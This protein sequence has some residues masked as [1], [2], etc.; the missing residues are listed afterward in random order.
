MW[1]RFGPIGLRLQHDKRFMDN[2]KSVLTTSSEADFTLMFVLCWGMWYR[3]NK[4]KME[5]ENITPYASTNMA[6]SLYK[7]FSILK[8]SNAANGKNL[9][10]WK[11]PP[12]DF[13]KLNVDG[14]VVTEYKKAGIGMVLCDSNGKV[15][16]AAT[17]FEPA[18]NE[19]STFE[20]LIVFRGLQMCLPLGIPKLIVESDYLL[21]GF[22][23]FFFLHHQK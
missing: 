22:Y 1:Q 11:S 5:S 15:V 21:I 4:L 13:L 10:R 18:V 19:P 20:L 6:I 17:I 7:S 3:R 8:V 12:S 2:V 9:C 23:F 14:A 16:M